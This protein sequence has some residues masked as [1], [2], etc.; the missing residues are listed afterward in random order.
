MINMNGDL[1][2]YYRDP[3][4]LSAD[5]NNVGAF[6]DGAFYFRGE[7]FAVLG[8]GEEEGQGP[9]AGVHEGLP[10]QQAGELEGG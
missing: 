9:P 5:F 3:V 8:G 1:Y 7:G 2:P 10:G 6:E 4:D